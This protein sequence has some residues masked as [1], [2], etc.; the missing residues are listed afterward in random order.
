VLCPQL[1]P[2][3]VVLLDDRPVHQA[4]RVEAEVRWPPAYSPDFAPIEEWWPKVK[5]L[6]RGRGRRIGQARLGLS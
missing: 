2:K 4:G 6:V 1:R 3:D 5:T